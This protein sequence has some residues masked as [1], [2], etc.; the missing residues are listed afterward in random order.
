[1]LARVMPYLTPPRRSFAW[2]SISLARLKLALL[3][4]VLVLC[5]MACDDDETCGSLPCPAGL[6]RGIDCECVPTRICSA[7]VDA[8]HQLFE[9]FEGT[10]F[11]NDCG[12]DTGCVVGGCSNEVCAAE[13]V[14]TT[15]ELLP[16]TPSGSCQCVDGQCIWSLCQA[17]WGETALVDGSDALMTGRAQL[18]AV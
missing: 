6:E 5:S 1:M 13:A 16:E 9:R 15:C 17:P 8:S 14:I 2:A 10:G 3:C 4:G 12:A 18:S 11:S 7:T